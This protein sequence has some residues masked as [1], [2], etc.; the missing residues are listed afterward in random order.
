MNV[1]GSVRCSGEGVEWMRGLG[2]GFI[3]III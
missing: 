2:L 3:I 1:F